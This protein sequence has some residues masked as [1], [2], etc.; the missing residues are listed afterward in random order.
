[1]K[2]LVL[3][4]SETIVDTSYESFLVTWNTYQSFFPDTKLYNGGRF[5]F[6]NLDFFFSNKEIVA[7][8]KKL[9]SYEKSAGEEVAIFLAIENDYNVNNEN[10][11]REFINGIEKEKLD[12]FY[13]QFYVERKCL[14]DI[15]LDKWNGLFKGNGK[16]VSAFNKY[17]DGL[18]IVSNK[19]KEAMKILLDN[20]G[21]NVEDNKIYD[22]NVTN[23]KLEKF[24]ILMKD[25][26][27]KPE[28]IIYIDDKL[29]HLLDLRELGIKLCMAS[30]FRDDDVS[31]AGDIVVLDED[32]VEGYLAEA[33]K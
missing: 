20:I 9:K 11:F 18:F 15:D 10:E 4:F 21:L 31:K 33:M 13:N 28:D 16:I 5:D 7:K 19:N 24:K 23:D 2:A 26:D 8:F 6:S 25:F 32:N 30:W 17:K 27:L 14:Q 22:T 12:K 1:M 3:D 29:A